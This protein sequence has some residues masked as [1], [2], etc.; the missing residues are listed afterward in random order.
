MLTLTWLGSFDKKLFY[1]FVQEEH[2]LT[3][4]YVITM[5]AVLVYGTDELVV[6]DLD[7]GEEEL[8]DEHLSV[9]R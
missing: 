3:Y 5:G 9:R 2:G 1:H 7:L 8:V 6:E 4:G